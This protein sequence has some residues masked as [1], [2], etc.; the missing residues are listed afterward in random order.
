M[1]SSVDHKI[2]LAKEEP[3]AIDQLATSRLQLLASADGHRFAWRPDKAPPESLSLEQSGLSALFSNS[4]RRHTPSA[5][6]NEHSCPASP[7][8]MPSS[9]PSALAFYCPGKREISQEAEKVWQPHVKDPSWAFQPDGFGLVKKKS[10]GVPKTITDVTYIRDG[11]RIERSKVGPPPPSFDTYSMIKPVRDV[12]L[13]MQQTTAAAGSARRVKA[14][15]LQQLL[16]PL[17][18]SI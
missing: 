4:S 16:Q 5:V 6:S 13:T 1:E 12:D 7:S 11:F 10:A 15:E 14:H 18:Q 2:V 8:T 3:L 17:H 9:V